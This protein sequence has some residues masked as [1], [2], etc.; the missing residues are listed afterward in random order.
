MEHIRGLQ[1][2]CAMERQT[3]G[4]VVLATVLAKVIASMPLKVPHQTLLSLAKFV[5]GLGE[6][7]MIDELCEFHSNEVNPQNHC[8]NHTVFEECHRTIPAD[9]PIAKVCIMTVAYNTTGAISK[10]RPQADVCDFVKLAD[11]RALESRKPELEI[12]E[13]FLRTMR[14]KYTPILGDFLSPKQCRASLRVLEEAT[15]RALLNK[16]SSGSVKEKSK[17]KE[18][19]TKNEITKARLEALE[20]SWKHYIENTDNPPTSSRWEFMVADAGSEED[21]RLCKNVWVIVIHCEYTNIGLP[22]HSYARLLRTSAC[23]C[24]PMLACYEHRLADAPICSLVANIG[25]PMHSYV[26]LTFA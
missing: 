1:R 8:V 4:K 9:C 24:T 25:L 5:N 11:L 26:S 17:K 20:C 3:A 18:K 6:G 2:A 16:A 14:V 10:V 22:M 21:N 12:V 23:R 19:G 15:V 13:S 7:P